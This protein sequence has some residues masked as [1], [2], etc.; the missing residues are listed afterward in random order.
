MV[1][2]HT[3]LMTVTSARTASHF[4]ALIKQDKKC[5]LRLRAVNVIVFALIARM[6]LSCNNRSFLPNIL[7]EQYQV[8]F[9]SPA[10]ICLFYHPCITHELCQAT[11]PFCSRSISCLQGGQNVPTGYYKAMQPVWTGAWSTDNS[12]QKKD[13]LWQ[14]STGQ[15]NSQRTVTCDDSPPVTITQWLPALTVR[16]WPSRQ[17]V[18]ACM[19]DSLQRISQVCL[20]VVC[21]VVNCLVVSCLA[22]GAVEAS[23]GLMGDLLIKKIPNQVSQHQNEEDIRQQYEYN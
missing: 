16:R 23:S 5:I 8:S 22:P 12:T 4:R 7:W 6:Q 17:Y 3:V 15:L 9:M 11:L 14:S 20:V 10:D 1:I 18:S 19:Y 2:Q 13:N 21:P